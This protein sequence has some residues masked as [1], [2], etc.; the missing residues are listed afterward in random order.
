MFLLVLKHTL[1]AF[2]GVLAHTTSQTV[3]VSKVVFDRKIASPIFP[4]LIRTVPIK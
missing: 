3:T 2:L 4:H 1:I